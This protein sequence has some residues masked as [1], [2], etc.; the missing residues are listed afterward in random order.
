MLLLKD[1]L[2]LVAA[3]TTHEGRGLLYAFTIVRKSTQV[4]RSP[5]WRR[6]P[7]NGALPDHNIFV[8]VSGTPCFMLR[9][10]M[11]LSTISGTPCFKLREHMRFR[12]NRQHCQTQNSC[13]THYKQQTTKK[14]NVPTRRRPRPFLSPQRG[15]FLLYENY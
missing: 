12:T 3:Q 14:E 11:C 9:E 8:N 5:Q 6:P 7:P 13:N 15:R 10:H 2:L 1:L 4:T